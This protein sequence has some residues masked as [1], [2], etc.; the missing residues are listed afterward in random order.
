LSEG[1]ASHGRP[2]VGETEPPVGVLVVDDSELFRA[3]LRDLVLATPGMTCIGE[4]DSGE[5]AVEA[6]ER[7]VPRLV[8]MDK[9]MP[10]LGGMA[11]SRL[12]RAR[13]PEIVVLL[14]SV[15]VPEPKVLEESGAAAFLNKQRLSPRV[16]AEAWRAH[17]P[18]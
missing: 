18:G 1:Q 7:L 10:G 8:I 9:R 6:V 3:L 4:E 11:T 15:E 17:A 2:R 13:H 12:I 14:V 5:A 16:L